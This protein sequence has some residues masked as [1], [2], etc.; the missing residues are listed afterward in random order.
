MTNRGPIILSTVAIMISLVSVWLSGT[1]IEVHRSIDDWA[2]PTGY[3]ASNTQFCLYRTSGP[4]V[5]P[6]GEDRPVPSSF[7][8]Q[9]DVTI[10]PER[11]CDEGCKQMVEAQCESLMAGLYV[12]APPGEQAR[13]ILGCHHHNPD[14]EPSFARGCFGRECK[15]EAPHAERK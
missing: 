3:W 4:D 15:P 11:V 8:K 10:T 13:H 1:R 12:Y 14:D 2:G 5:I 9:G 7:A 6:C